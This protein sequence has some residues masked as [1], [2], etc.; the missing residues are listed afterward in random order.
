MYATKSRFSIS[1]EH[2]AEMYTYLAVSNQGSK[3]TGKCFEDP[4]RVVSTSF[5]QEIFA[6]T[7]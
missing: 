1:P 4:T 2:M 6:A 5:N 7:G 3:I